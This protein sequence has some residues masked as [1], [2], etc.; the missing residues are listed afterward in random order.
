[1][2]NSNYDDSQ[3]Y[4][5][6]PT[7]N[8]TESSSQYQSP[9]MITLSDLSDD[10]IS[11]LLGLNVEVTLKIENIMNQEKVKGNIF[12]IMKNNNLLI[13]LRR[14]GNEKNSINTFMINIQSIQSIKLSE[15]KFDVK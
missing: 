10:S 5:Q 13:L 4:F 1:M 6:N 8:K 3:I 12:S 2:S 7:E 9:N 11:N 15:E 14:D